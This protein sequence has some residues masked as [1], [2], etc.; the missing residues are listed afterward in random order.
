MSQNKQF[1]LKHTFRKLEDLNVIDNFLFQSMLADEQDG[2]TFVRILLSTILGK[3][4][5]K[6]KIVPQKSILGTDTDKHGIRL[7][8]YI[9][10]I[11]NEVNTNLADVEIIPD[12]YDIEP[13]NIYEKTSLPR[14]TRYYH[15]L[16]DTQLLSSGIH[17]DKLPNMFI[18][19]ILPYDPFGKNRMVYTISNH[20]EEDTTIPYDDGAKKI[21]LYTKGSE[22]NP[23]QALRDMLKY[24]EKSTDDNVTNSDIASIQELVNKV[25]L[26]K[27]VGINYM[28]SWEV[29]YIARKEGFN[30]GH[31]NMQEKMNQLT[32]RL[33]HA[34]RMDDIVKAAG[35]KTYQEK[36]FQEFNL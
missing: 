13:N 26:K 30:E 33:A 35:D 9:E 27:E 15:G 28:K 7:D 8:A 25:K 22:G 34:G 29:E 6:V 20:C 1:N 31:Q 18:I 16:I 32:L 23:S 2:E 14:R 19:F 36:L 3:K 11:S 5:R 12:I 21:F 24:I 4:I 10:D 17:Y